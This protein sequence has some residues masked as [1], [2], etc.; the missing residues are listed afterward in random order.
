MKYSVNKIFA[1]WELLNG[2]LCGTKAVSCSGNIALFAR[3]DFLFYLSSYFPTV[4]SADT[5][6]DFMIVGNIQQL[7]RAVRLIPSRDSPQLTDYSPHII[8]STI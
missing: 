6:N 8:V 2:G 4:C 5:L 3:I 1:N 7:H